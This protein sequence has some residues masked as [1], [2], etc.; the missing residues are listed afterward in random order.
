MYLF[1]RRVRLVPGQSRDSLA[2]AIDQTERVNR[3]TGLS[4]SAYT[5]M[6]SP[7]V[8]TIAWSAF[9]P[10]LTTLEEAADKLAVDDEFVS[11]SDQG[12]K[13]ITGGA[14]DALG[15]VLHGEPDPMRTVEYV[16]TVRAVC[17][18]GRLSQGLELGATLAADAERV[19]GVPTLFVAGRTGSYG[20][21]AWIAGHTDIRSMEA[22]DQA[23][24]ADTGWRERIDREAASVYASDPG[25]TE[26]RV[27]RHIA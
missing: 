2:W 17:G 10:D 19:T 15:M 16:T 3:I 13:F 22:A 26:Q 4:A 20:A 6:F 11:A 24:S 27:Y 12:A 7:E 18:P 21:V 25:S 14:H 1:T 8:G 5:L 9:V 23:L